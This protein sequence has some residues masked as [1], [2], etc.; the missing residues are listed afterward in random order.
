MVG[1]RTLN[2][3]IMVR[4]HVPQQDW[5]PNTTS[6][7]KARSCLLNVVLFW[8]VSDRYLCCPLVIIFMKNR[9]NNLTNRANLETWGTLALIVS[10]VVGAFA[11][12]ASKTALRELT[13]TMILFLR[14]SFMV[15]TLLPF[16]IKKT[17]QLLTHWKILTIIGLLWIGNIGGYILGIKY[18]TAI[19]SSVIYTAVPLVVLLLQRLILHTRAT[20]L[21]KVGIGLGLV[22]ALLVILQNADSTIIGSFKG[23][24]IISLAIT[25]YSLYLVISKKTSH[26]SPLTLL[27]G[28]SVIG[29]IISL[30][31]LLA[32]DGPIAINIIGNASQKAWIAV[33]FLGTALGGGTYGVTQWGVKHSSPLV[34]GMVGYL[35]LIVASGTGILFLGEKPAIQTT[36]GCILIIIGVSVTTILPI[37]NSISINT[38]K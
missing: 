22:G 17:S 23:N 4:I 12:L 36:L 8:K 6:Y 2:P 26:L 11:A 29:W 9:I 24:L 14:V 35:A 1:Q 30:G 15:A 20:K 3:S 16:I 5:T 31:L 33:I 38:K 34:A 37:V 32:I 21:Q 25:S 27:S 10:A 19:A 13:P 7:K 28:S 18:T